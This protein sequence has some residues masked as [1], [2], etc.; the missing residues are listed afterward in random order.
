M[1]LSENNI[2]NA[3]ETSGLLAQVTS[4]IT[5]ADMHYELEAEKGL[6]YLR[7]CLDSGTY[8]AMLSVDDEEGLRRIT[9]FSTLPIKAPAQSRMTTLEAINHINYALAVGNFEMD[10]SDGEIRLR[11][12]FS[13]ADA[14][15]TEEMF[16]TLLSN[17]FSILDAYVPKLMRVVFGGSKP[18]DVLLSETPDSE[19]VQ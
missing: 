18:E 2:G 15:M 4:F 8:S 3:A 17:T 1:D 9:T 12:G 7:M 10:M 5:S 13:L 6:V 11:T 16:N 19:T 14:A